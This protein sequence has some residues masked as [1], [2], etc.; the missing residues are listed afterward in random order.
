MTGN[1]GGSACCV[2][3]SGTRWHVVLSC[4]L[5][6]TPA[7]LSTQRSIPA[8]CLILFSIL[9]I[10]ETFK[11]EFFFVVVGILLSFEPIER[12]HVHGALDQ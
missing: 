4:R 3:M 11:F 7:S 12:S 10:S 1:C 2:C 5:T 6:S 8:P 9:R